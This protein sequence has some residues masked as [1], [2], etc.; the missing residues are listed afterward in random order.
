M[1]RPRSTGL[2]P[3]QEE[4]LRAIRN[5]IAH[6]GMPP[7]VRELAKEMNITSSTGFY[8]MRELEQKGMIRRGALGAR[9]L[10]VGDQSLGCSCE[11][12]P[13]LGVIAA[14]GPIEAI[15][16]HSGTIT[17]ERTLLNGAKGFALRVAGQSMIDAGILDGDFVIVRKQPVVENGDVVVALIENEATL[18]RFYRQGKQVRLEPANRAMSP[19]FVSGGEFKIQGK[20]V[21][22]IRKMDAVN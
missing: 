2:T 15:E 4:A 16:N 12:L 14:G 5:F 1:A 11:E 8:L 7:T 22:V 3:R 18:K 21:R 6:H 10:I 13:V 17:V 19:I 20:V 9:S